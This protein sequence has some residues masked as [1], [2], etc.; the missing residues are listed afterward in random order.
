MLQH[1]SIL[2]SSTLLIALLSAIAD[3]GCVT[4]YRQSVGVDTNQLYSRIYLTDFNTAWQ[5]VLD[6]LKHN[7][8]D[9][10][11]REGG[12]VQTRWT[13]NTAE[14]NFTDSFGSADSYLKAQYRVRVTVAKGFYNGRP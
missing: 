4:A 8:L 11:N 7:R 9:V 1:P 12:F 14:K 2:R 10:S 3:S 6:G 5:S 13:D